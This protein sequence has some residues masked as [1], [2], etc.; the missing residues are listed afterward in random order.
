MTMSL[1]FSQTALAQSP[2]P[3]TDTETEAEPETEQ[4]QD[5]A[6]DSETQTQMEPET[7]TQTERPTPQCPPGSTFNRG[8]CEVPHRLECPSGT[9]ESADGLRCIIETVDKDPVCTQGKYNPETRKC[10]V[11]PVCPSGTTPDVTGTKCTTSI[12]CP[13]D[14]FVTSVVS[15]DGGFSCATSPIGP[16]T[17][18]TDFTFISFRHFCFKPACPSGTTTLFPSTRC[19]AERSSCP[20]GAFNKETRRCELEPTLQ[21]PSGTEENA[22]GRCDRLVN[23]ELVCLSGTEENADGRC[24]RLVNKVEQCPSGTKENEATGKCETRPGRQNA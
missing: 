18:P 23:K 11:D 10:E 7:E 22:D 17:C 14:S 12:S 2:S 13:P 6:T 24:D 5:T 15:L 16:S 19:E 1:S 21:C 3:Q 20:S 9:R 4:E 8:V